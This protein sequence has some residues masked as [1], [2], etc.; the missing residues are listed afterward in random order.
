MAATI[1]NP[2][3]HYLAAAR[4]EALTEN[5]DAK[6][7][8]LLL[9]CIKEGDVTVA[10]EYALS[11]YRAISNDEDADPGKATMGCLLVEA[12]ASK[13]A[14]A[15]AY[16]IAED[17]GRLES[18]AGTRAKLELLSQGYPGP[19]G[20][21]L[22]MFVEDHLFTPPPKGRHGSDHMQDVRLYL[23][24]LAGC[25]IDLSAPGSKYTTLYER[26]K[27]LEI[28]PWL[29][30]ILPSNVAQAYH[31][32]GHPELAVSFADQVHQHRI[33]GAMLLAMSEQA[34]DPGR[35]RAI[36]GEV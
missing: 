22:D 4:M 23:Y 26:V 18:C 2:S 5:D 11:A 32:G 21:L 10:G 1:R 3:A 27:A 13:G 19:E 15:I 29:S 14:F 24:A 35:L 8:G 36:A 28:D 6:R 33:R 34:Q 20:E 7:A 9:G 31:A 16:Q 17:L 12:L 25:G 30:Q